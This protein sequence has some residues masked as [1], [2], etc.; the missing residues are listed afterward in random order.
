[1]APGVHARGGRGGKGAL[2]I[3]IYKWTG[4]N[5]HHFNAPPPSTLSLGGGEGGRPS[6]WSHPCNNLVGCCVVFHWDKTSLLNLITT[7]T[8][9]LANLNQNPPTYYVLCIMYSMWTN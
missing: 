4:V 1:M 6:L 8:N 2:H 3:G 5:G 9:V 7:Y